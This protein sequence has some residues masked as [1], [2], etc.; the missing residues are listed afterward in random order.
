[1]PVRISLLLAVTTDPTDRV[2][3]SPHSGGWSESFYAPGNQFAALPFFVLWA[4]Q[5]ANILAGECA[6]VGY[7]QQ[8]FTI[9]QNKLL[10]GGSAGGALNVPGGW[11]NDLNA[12]QDSLMVNFQV[13]GQPQ[14]IR[15]RLPGIPDSQVSAGEYQPNATF[16]A[17]LTKYIQLITAGVFEALVHDLTQPDARVRSLAGA[18]LTTQ[19]AT[20]A[21]AGGY[22]RFRRVKDDIG[23]P[24]EGAFL[25]TAVV[26][27]ADGSFT[28]TLFD[29]PLQT[30]STPNGTCRHDL[31]VEANIVGGNP[32]RLVIRK[33]G[34]PFAQ[35]RGRRSKRKV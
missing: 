17:A 16:K 32:N 23:R 3:A 4:N 13:A 1:M 14:N 27:N 19:S 21:I 10:P 33:V 15:H 24:V 28:Y 5:R 31:L 8:L 12:P 20:G 30:V 29:P 35:Y 18:A 34:R 2:A 7:R 25:V 11:P 9:S 22:I 6:V 26:A